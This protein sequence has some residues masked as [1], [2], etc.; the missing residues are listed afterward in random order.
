LQGVLN[1][2]NNSI[3]SALTGY[4]KEENVD[5]CMDF[6]DSDDS[7]DT[8]GNGNH[9]VENVK[10][11]K[12]GQVDFLKVTQQLKPS[13]TTCQHRDLKIARREILTGSL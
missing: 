6:N 4:I 9:G 11:I 12:E 3:T 8:N 2:I 13:T 1:D 7:D 5:L 10:A